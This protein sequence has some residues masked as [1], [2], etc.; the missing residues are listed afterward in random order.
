M[1]FASLPPQR[2]CQQIAFCLELTTWVRLLGA[3]NRRLQP[4]RRPATW[5]VFA[6]M[7]DIRRSTWTRACHVVTTQRASM[8]KP[9]RNALPFCAELRKKLARRCR[10][11]RRDRFTSLE[12]RSRLR[13]EK[14]QRG[15]VQPRRWSKMFIALWTSFAPR[16][17]RMA[18]SPPGRTW[19]GWSFNLPWNSAIPWFSTTIAR[20][21]I[22]CR[23]DCLQVL[24]LSTRPIPPITSPPPL[25]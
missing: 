19:S 18:C 9:S 11:V 14:W 22:R 10:L 16:S 17:E 5:P 20:K 2:D 15:N 23:Q 6:F 12:R 1:Q 25:S 8:R 13:A 21:C 3:V 4:W 24:R 7:R